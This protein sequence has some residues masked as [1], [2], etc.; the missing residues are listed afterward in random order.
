MEPE[1][2][3]IC[4]ELLEHDIAILICNHQFHFKCITA[5]MSC[6]N[7]YTNFC[8]YCDMNNEI[9]NVINVKNDYNTSKSTEIVNSYSP[10]PIS[11]PPLQ[12]LPPLLQPLP[13]PIPP[14]PLQ[15]LPPQARHLPPIPRRLPINRS[16][17]PPQ[18][19]QSE[20]KCI[21]S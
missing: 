8:I 21:I 2:C 17:R 7:N 18:P 12:P 20:K 15:P 10:P 5:W 9:T 3:A 16:N 6:K 11:P 4:L 14:P 1:E 19:P 13:P